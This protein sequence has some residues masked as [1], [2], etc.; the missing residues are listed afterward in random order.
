MVS[1]L[2][3][4][5]AFPLLDDQKLLAYPNAPENLTSRHKYCCQCKQPKA[6]LGLKYAAIASRNFDDEP[7]RDDAAV[8]RSVKYTTPSVHLSL[9]LSFEVG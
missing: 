9:L 1:G 4:E 7:V 8:S 3:L 6:L 2:F 5:S